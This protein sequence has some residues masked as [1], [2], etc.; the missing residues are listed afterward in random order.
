MKLKLPKR[1][2]KKQIKSFGKNSHLHLRESPKKKKRSVNLPKPNLKKRVRFDLILK[3]VVLLTF[4]FSIGGIF[5]LGT[6]TDYFWIRNITISGNVDSQLSNSIEA[7]FI[8]RNLVGLS[9]NEVLDFIKSQNSRV[10]SVLVRKIYP[11]NLELDITIQV[12]RYL[13][14]NF[15]TA[16]LLNSDFEVLEGLGL[17]EQLNLSTLEQNL[18]DSTVDYSD[19]L[20]AQAFIKTLE[21][22]EREQFDWDEV[23]DEEKQNFFD[24]LTS[25]VNE[26]VINHFVTEREIFQTIIPE[27]EDLIIVDFYNS[28]DSVFANISQME[29]LQTVYD[30]LEE[31]NYEPQSLEWLTRLKLEIEIQNNIILVF[32]TKTPLIEEE[33]QIRALETVI[34]NGEL[35]SNRVYDFRSKNFGVN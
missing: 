26:K 2:S 31:S 12:P 8:N 14:L 3:F 29:L 24:D 1:N 30:F 34:N 28:E 19:T 7:E 6:K 18:Y 20:I 17:N 35:Q 25:Q 22:E 23:Q 21:E 9:N 5:Y 32:S 10:E 15:D 13:I 27:Y 33:D 4:I 11:E 16:F